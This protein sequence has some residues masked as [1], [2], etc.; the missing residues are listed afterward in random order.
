MFDGC[1]HFRAFKNFRAQ[2]P[3]N[4]FDFLTRYWDYNGN[5]SVWNHPRF[6]GDGEV[7]TFLSD[8]MSTHTMKDK[9]SYKKS[10]I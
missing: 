7:P 6:L 8:S 3:Y 9:S 2:Y 5:E 10:S 4:T 1:Y